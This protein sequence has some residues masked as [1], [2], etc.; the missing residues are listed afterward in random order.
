MRRD[1]IVRACRRLAASEAIG[2]DVRTLA[3]FVLFD[4]DR[5]G[6]YIARHYFSA[7]AKAERSNQGEE[8]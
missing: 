2:F 3:R 6:Q 5:H 4:D 8:S 7:A 1:L